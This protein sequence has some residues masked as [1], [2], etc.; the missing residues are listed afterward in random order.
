MVD[1]VHV[2][3]GLWVGVVMCVRLACVRAWGQVCMIDHTNVQ[4]LPPSAIEAM[5]LG[6]E[7]RCSVCVCVCVFVHVCQCV[8]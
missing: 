7:N 8:P 1:N 3:W 5:M 4:G 6:D 2:F